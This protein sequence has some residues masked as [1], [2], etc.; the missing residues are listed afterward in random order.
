[1]NW[2]HQRVF[3]YNCQMVVNGGGYL[4][5]CCCAAAVCCCCFR[6]AAIRT[7]AR[8]AWIEEQSRQIIAHKILEFIII[9]LEFFNSCFL[10]N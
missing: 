1:M 6:L 3:S 4:H 5:C 10:L 8:T 9:I 7:Y 2:S